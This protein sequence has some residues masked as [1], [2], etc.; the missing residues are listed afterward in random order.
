MQLPDIHL[1]GDKGY[2]LD[3]RFVLL[4]SAD[5]VQFTTDVSDNAVI[6]EVTNFKGTFF[7]DHFR[8]KETIF[9]AK[10]S[11]EVDLKKIQI[12]AGV[13]FGKQTLAD[14]RMV[15]LIEA[16][17][18]DMDIDRRDIKIHLHGNIWTDFGSLFE[19][20]FKG[21]VI[22]MIQDTAEAA[23]N[24]GIPLIGNT[25]M[26]KLDGYFPVPVV[27]NWIVDWETP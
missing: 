24:A 12:T 18:V 8:Y 6:F 27:P 23:M 10:G 25:V 9:V 14:G 20:F 11:I 4:E 3:N 2:M 5:D 7:C 13:G 16:V 19:V 22:D 17:N 15:P 21:T 26:T 1:D